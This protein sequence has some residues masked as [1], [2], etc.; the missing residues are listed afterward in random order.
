MALVIWGVVSSETREWNFDC[1]PY[2]AAAR[3]QLGESHAAA[4]AA[5]YRDLRSVAP[6][7]KLNELTAGSQYRESVAADP[8]VLA[9]QLPMYWNK[10][11]YVSLVALLVASGWSDS[12][13]A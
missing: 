1:I 10:P 13:S 5:V 7:P 6:A 8:E 11:A 3:A 4:H 12:I 9:V 2:A